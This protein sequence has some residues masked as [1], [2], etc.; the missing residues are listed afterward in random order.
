MPGR[1]F[2]GPPS[3]G[4]VSG[5]AH[6]SVYL[7]PVYNGRLVVYDVQAKEARGRWLPWD[8]LDFGANPYE[9]ASALA[10]EWCGVGLSD[11]SLVDVMSFPVEGGGWELTLIFRAELDEGPRGDNTRT[12]FVFAPGV[13][14]AIGPFDPVDL[15]R[16]IEGPIAAAPR[17][18]VQAPPPE[19]G[20]LL[21]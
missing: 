15:Q 12:P 6:I 8:V 19:Q 5:G 17:P 20:G 16:W 9:A 1:A 13:V 21:F 11:L 7:V 2:F 10:D 4:F 18:H 3:D 14:D